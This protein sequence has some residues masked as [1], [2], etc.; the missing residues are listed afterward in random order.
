MLKS[1]I[2]QFA[3][4]PSRDQIGHMMAYRWIRAFAGMTVEQ[5]THDL[6]EI[7]NNTFWIDPT[8]DNPE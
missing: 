3:W 4:M 5:A 1:V 7:A 2:E 8:L 6:P